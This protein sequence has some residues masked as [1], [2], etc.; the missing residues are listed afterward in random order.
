MQTPYGLEI[1]EDC[2]TCKVRADRMFCD[3]PAEALAAFDAITYANLHPHGA[4]LFVEGQEPRGVYVVCSGRVKLSTCSADGKTIITDIAEPGEILGL[5]ATVSGQPHEVTAEML[6]P[7]QTNFVKREE[8]MRFLRE[9]GEASLK[10]AEHLSRNYHT[11][12][13]KIRS[14]GLSVTASERL[15]RLLLEWA[16]KGVET[17]QGTRLKLTLTQE[18]IAE[19]IGTSR[20]TV[21]RL[22]SDFK[23][24]QIVHLK[25]STLTIRN[26]AALQSLIH[27]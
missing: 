3:L 26:Q 1:I 2:L 6:E 21:T 12:C 13:Q 24:K 4:V 8:F 11:A 19:L 15:A 18:E 7:G 16:A 10:V 25:G 14:L 9:Y 23:K 22:F 20:E 27:S 17:D 5:S